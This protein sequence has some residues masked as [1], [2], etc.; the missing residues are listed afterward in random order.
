MSWWIFA[1]YWAAILVAFV[2]AAIYSRRRQ[3]RNET[4]H[5]LFG[6]GDYSYSCDRCAVP[7]TT[8]THHKIW[9]AQNDEQEKQF[10]SGGTA[11]V[12]DF[13]PEHC[14]GECDRGCEKRGPQLGDN[15]TFLRRSDLH[16]ELGNSSTGGETR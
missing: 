7:L 11:M 5:D 10:S 2:G 3:Q 16:P 6:L 9:E 4:T 13:C 15:V 1:I 8:D 14:E 12:A